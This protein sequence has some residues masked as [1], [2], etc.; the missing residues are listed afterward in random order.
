MFREGVID[1]SG[2][3]PVWLSIVDNIKGD[4]CGNGVRGLITRLF[5]HLIAV[6]CRGCQENVIDISR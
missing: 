5:M 3:I 6:G 2:L 4:S 1:L